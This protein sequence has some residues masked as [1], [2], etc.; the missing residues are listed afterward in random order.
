M[1][2]T[3]ENVSVVS[4]IKFIDVASLLSLFIFYEMLFFKIPVTNW[5]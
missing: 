2:N 3:M 4:F 1:E 5:D